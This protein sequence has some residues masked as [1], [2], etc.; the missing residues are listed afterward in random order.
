MNNKLEKTLL[1]MFGEPIF[2]DV[3]GVISARSDAT[4]SPAPPPKSID[5]IA[6]STCGELPIDDSCACAGG[7][8]CPMCGQ[9]P[10]KIDTICSCNT[11]E[12]VNQCS[13]SF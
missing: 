7:K 9:M 13:Q 4:S 8:V 10:T 11:G 1:E 2:V 12:T 5:V 6:C 3:K